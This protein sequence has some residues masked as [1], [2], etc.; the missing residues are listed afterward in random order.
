MLGFIWL[1]CDPWTVAHQTPVHGISQ[2]RILEWVT[3]PFSRGL[4]QLRIEPTSPTLAG[5]FFATE[6]PGKPIF[7]CIV[8][9]NTWTVLCSHHRY[10]SAE[11]LIFPNW[12]SIPIRALIPH[13]SIHEPLSTTILLLS[14][15]LTTLDIS[16]KCNCTMF[17]LL[18]LAYFT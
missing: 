6:L 10:P 11:I 1:S 9:L 5:G 13:S 8:T 3:I 12:N 4:S 2:A 16:Y 17:V 14:M 15:N 7:K 18:W